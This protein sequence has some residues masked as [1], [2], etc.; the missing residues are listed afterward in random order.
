MSIH[1]AV[2]LANPK[3]HTWIQDYVAAVGPLLKKHGGKVL[4]RSASHKR[5]EGAGAN[6][7][8]MVIVEWPSLEAADAFYSDPAYQPHLKARL[9]GSTCDGFIVEAKDDFA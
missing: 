1:Y 8:V 2:F 6:P 5:F 7:A 9:N 3:T 4:A